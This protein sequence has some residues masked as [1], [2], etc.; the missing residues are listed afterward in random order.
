MGRL[1]WAELDGI[2]RQH[3]VDT[4]WSW[5]RIHCFQV[6]PFEYLLKYIQHVKEDRNDCIYATMGG[7]SH[8]IIEKFYSGKIKYEDM[9]NEFYDGWAVHREISNLK[10]D[11]NDDGHDEQIAA[12][13]YFDLKHFFQNHSAL[14]YKPVLEQFV[15]ANI[16]GNVLQ[17]YI[18]CCF[19]DDDGCYNIIDWKTSTIYKGSKAEEECGQLVIYAIALHQMG[20]PFDKL[21]IAWNFLKF[22]NVEYMQKNGAVKTRE[23]E[24]CKIG[25]SLKSNA[26]IW[27]K[28]AG[29]DNDDIEMYISNLTD[30]NELSVL[31]KEVQKKYK[32]SDCY[33]YVPLTKEL[34]DRWYNEVNDTIKD[35]VSKEKMYKSTHD[36]SI[37]WDDEESVKK[38]SY[39]FSTLCGYS[40]NLHKPYKQY[41]NAIGV[42]D[43][44]GNGGPNNKTSESEVSKVSTDSDDLSWLN[45][46]L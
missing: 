13:Y 25:E 17:G 36:E 19:K 2:K 23:I 14:R 42:T 1:S 9:I 45:D 31:P 32:V 20:V 27:L 15:T 39:Y 3:G 11:R 38:E 12:K 26:R 22:C 7:L 16:G 37:W 10:F 34:I 41:L 44:F 43:S 21:K 24:R 4:L 30:T 28:N 6:S 40:A 46:I 35:I 18:D 33:V 5:S 8:D 29:Y